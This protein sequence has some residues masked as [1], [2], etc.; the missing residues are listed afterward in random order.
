MSS[1]TIP[2]KVG[3]TLKNKHTGDL[4]TIQKVEYVSLYS[5]EKGRYEAPVFILGMKNR[6][7]L[8]N[9]LQHWEL[10]E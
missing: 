2:Y 1:N 3:Q 9:I 4:E 7:N 6:F 8:D 5:L 10:V